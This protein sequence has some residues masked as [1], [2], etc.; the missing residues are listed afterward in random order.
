MGNYIPSC[1]LS[2]LIGTFFTGVV[3]VKAQEKLPYSSLDDSETVREYSALFFD[4]TLPVSFDLV[5]F[6]PCEMMADLTSD[7]TW[8]ERSRDCSEFSYTSKMYP[9]F[10]VS[11]SSIWLGR[12]GYDDYKSQ[13]DRWSE[14]FNISYEA[15]GDNWYVI[16]GVGKYSGDIFYLRS[17]DG[18]G[19]NTKLN[20]RYPADQLEKYNELV[21]EIVSSFRGK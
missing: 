13:Y 11:V 6:S 14:T 2:V 18:K 1:C 10:M 4:L 8:M 19:Y 5:F 17:E 3:S 21:G 15:K 20:L 12:M 7:S 9:E 16:S